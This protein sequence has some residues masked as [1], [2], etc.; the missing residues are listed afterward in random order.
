MAS[1]RQPDPAPQPAERDALV[2]TRP[3]APDHVSDDQTTA[4]GSRSVWGEPRE[5][6]IAVALALF[7]V[8]CAIVAP[9]AIRVHGIS[10]FDEAT[11]ADYAYQVAHGHI[12]ARGSIIDPTI[13]TEIVCRGLAA[14]PD[15][16]RTNCGKI[17]PPAALFGGADNYNYS[18]PPLYYLITGVLARAAGLP[19]SGNHFILFARL[20]GILWLFA[21][22]LV[23]YLAL[24]RFRVGWPIAA[25][26]AGMLAMTPA[27]YYPAATVTNDAAA[28]LSG[29]LA[30]LL[31]ARITVDGKLGWK[32]PALLGL[33]AAATK[34][35]NAVPLLAVAAVVLVLGLREWRVDRTRALHCCG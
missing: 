35:L 8:A 7:V 20:V 31:L 18:H 25:V 34:I 22:M 33:L 19:F 10:V 12:P 29:S 17:N 16:P 4:P 28:A 13:R 11:H 15:R 26:G 21:A 27:L 3:T 32:L 6:L 2:E 1:S 24:R 30:V 14:E 9:A 23:L 5:R